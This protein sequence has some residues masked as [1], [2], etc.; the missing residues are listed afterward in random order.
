MAWE[1]HK[2]F[3]RAQIY[4]LIWENIAVETDLISK[5]FIIQMTMTTLGYF[6]NMSCRIFLGF[7]DQG[8]LMFVL[9]LCLNILYD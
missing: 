5:V 9:L 7:Q 3:G 4:I 2:A 6:K 8:R 1:S